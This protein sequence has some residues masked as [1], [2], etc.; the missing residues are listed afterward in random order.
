MNNKQLKQRMI[1]H[2]EAILLPLDAIPADAV[3]DK[4]VKQFIVAHSESGH[5]HLAVGDITLFKNFDVS[6]LRQKLSKYLYEGAEITGL[7]RVN[8][9]SI[10]E[11]QKSFDKHET[12][13]LLKGNYLVIL[14][15]HYDYFKKAI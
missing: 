8:Q 13:P 7:F 14:K 12:K 10:L 4:N 15:Q 5:H 11:H 6:S 9:D 3:E 1:R 2:G